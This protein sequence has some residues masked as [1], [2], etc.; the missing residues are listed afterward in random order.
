MYIY[1][2]YIQYFRG[3]KREDLSRIMGLGVKIAQGLLF[4]FNFIFVVSIRLNTWFIKHAVR[5][6]LA[7]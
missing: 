3:I 6:G 1:T 7:R 2:F 4:A 5:T